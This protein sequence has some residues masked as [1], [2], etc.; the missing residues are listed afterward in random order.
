MS[1]I[2]DGLNASDKLLFVEDSF[3]ADA[4]KGKGW[5]VLES[6]DSNELG[7]GVGKDIKEEVDKVK[8]D[9]DELTDS[10]KRD[11]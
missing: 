1:P 3:R 5:I 7:G 4:F 2:V 10:I 6:V 8:D 9:F 11:L